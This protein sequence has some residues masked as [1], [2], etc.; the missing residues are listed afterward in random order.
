MT[1]QPSPPGV[2]GTDVDR[3]SPPGVPR[4]VKLSVLIVGALI[5]VVV[6]L[7]LTR[8]LGGEHGPGRHLP[9]GGNPGGHSPPVQHGP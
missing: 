6:V 7:A 4:W 9:G 2:D 1:D 5:L 8:V 3:R